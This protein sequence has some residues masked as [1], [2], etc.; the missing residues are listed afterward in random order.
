MISLSTGTLLLVLLTTQE[1]NLQAAEL[2]GGRTCQCIDT[3]LNGVALLQ[4]GKKHNALKAVDAKD[5]SGNVLEKANEA[6]AELKADEAIWPFTAAD[7]AEEMSLTIA[8]AK[9]ISRAFT[10][11]KKAIKEAANAKGSIEV[12]R[13]QKAKE[14][15]ALAMEHLAEAKDETEMVKAIQEADDSLNQSHIVMEEAVEVKGVEKNAVKGYKA[16]RINESEAEGIEAEDEQQPQEAESIE[17]EDEQQPQDAEEQEG[18]EEAIEEKMEKEREEAAK[19]GKADKA[20]EAEEVE[21]EGFLP[22][23]IRA[24]RRFFR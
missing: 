6:L 14:E 4:T 23:F 11:A 12:E 21:S 3:H 24:V 17:A 9:K 2:C 10:A 15:A 1:L 16:Y 19:D 18:A 22:R 5:E 20:S 13:A 7:E 8:D